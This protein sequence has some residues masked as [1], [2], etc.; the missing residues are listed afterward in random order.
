MILTPSIGLFYGGSDKAGSL[1]KY[2]WRTN[3][4]KRSNFTIPIQLQFGKKNCKN[5]GIA[6]DQLVRSRP[7]PLRNR[8]V[9]LRSAVDKLYKLGWQWLAGHVTKP[10]WLPGSGGKSIGGRISIVTVPDPIHP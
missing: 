8:P 7:A 5:I 3:L 6:A 4:G 9:R 2:E 10:G 1:S